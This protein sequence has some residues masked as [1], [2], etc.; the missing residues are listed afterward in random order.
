MKKTH[1]SPRLMAV[2]RFIP[3][4]VRIADIGADHAHL[5][6]RAVQEGIAREAIA[7]EVKK[8]PYQQ[9][10][11]SVTELGMT[12][13]VS[14]RLGDGL[15]VIRRGEVNCIVIAGMGGELITEILERGRAKLNAGTT[16]ILQPNIREPLVRDWLNAHGWQIVGETVAEEP[17]HFYEVICARFSGAAQPPLSAAERLMGPILV[18]SRPDT[19]Q[20]KWAS[21]QRKLQEVLHALERTVPTEEILMKKAECVGRLQLIHTVLSADETG[22]D[23]K[24]NN[25]AL[26][27]EMTFN[28]ANIKKRRQKN[29]KLDGRTYTD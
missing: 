26:S 4:G 14:V 25:K 10:V 7:G 13:M 1:L 6:C 5:C 23:R 17:P 3:S 2:L 11:N 27:R 15:D 8:G 12:G 28:R 20:R 21:K 18:H 24:I 9:S 19:F 16:L 22:T 29:G